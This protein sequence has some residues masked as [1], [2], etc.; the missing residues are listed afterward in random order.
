MGEGA[1]DARPGGRTAADPLQ[2]ARLLADAAEISATHLD[3]ESHAAELYAVVVAL[4][5]T[6]DNLAEKLADIRQRRGDLMG[7]LPLAERLAARAE[8]QPPAE[9]ARL[10]HR[11]GRAREAAGDE[12]GACDAYRQAAAGQGSEPER[13]A[14]ADLA[15]LCFR[16]E[17]WPDAA[18]AYERLARPATRSRARPAAAGAAR[19]FAAARGDA[20]AAISPLEQA[21]ALEAAAPRGLAGH[22]RGGPCGRR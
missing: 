10:Y 8:G 1:A 6:R 5:D 3:D 22:R 18:A 12:A 20:T 19:R 21:L 14:L 16:R 2:R 13:V 15:A 17:E 9:Q 4:D 11:L 7:L